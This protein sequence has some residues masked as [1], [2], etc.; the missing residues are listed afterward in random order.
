MKDPV[1]LPGGFTVIRLAH[2][3]DDG[4]DHRIRRV[5]GHPETKQFEKEVKTN[6]MNRMNNKNASEEEL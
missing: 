2:D 4:G 6:K 5:V 3:P 1:A